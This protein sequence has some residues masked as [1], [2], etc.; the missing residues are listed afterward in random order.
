MGL[1]II[2]I[3]AGVYDELPELTK[4]VAS[5]LKFPFSV[6]HDTD[7]VINDAYDIASY[8]VAYLIG[9]DGKVIWEGVPDAGNKSQM[10]LLEGMVA[11]SLKKLA[12]TLGPRR[13]GGI[14]WMAG[15]AA[16]KRSRI[17]GKRILLYKDWPR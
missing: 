9:A 12:P 17:E 2:D 6:V 10:S 15:S 5:H 13:D 3:H 7:N 14:Q 16:A 8:P 4:H 1:R 11:A